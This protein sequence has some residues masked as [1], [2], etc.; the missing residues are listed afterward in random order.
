[1]GPADFITLLHDAQ[2]ELSCGGKGVGS[3][4]Q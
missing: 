2:E 1:M 4:S 3:L